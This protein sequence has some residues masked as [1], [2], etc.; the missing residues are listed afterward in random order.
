VAS[1]AALAAAGVDDAAVSVS[2]FR[3][4]GV[5]RTLDG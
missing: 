4:G 1:A 3:S 2:V 5:S